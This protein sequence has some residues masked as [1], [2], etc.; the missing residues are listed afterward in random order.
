MPIDPDAMID[1]LLEYGFDTD[2]V[3]DD[4]EIRMACPL[5]ADD[6]KRLYIE[7]ESGIWLCFRCDERGDL[8]DLFHRVLGLDVQESFE[9]RRKVRHRPEPEFRFGRQ[10]PAPMP[11]I[12]LPAEF[13][14]LSVDRRNESDQGLY[15][16]YLAGRHVPP[17]RAVAYGM[18]V[19]ASGY[20]ANRLIIPVRYRDHLYTFVARALD[21]AEPKV[22]YP[23]GSRRSD[24]LFNL[25]R[26]E[27][28]V[29]LHPLV[30]TEGAFD[31]LRMPNCAVA[32]LGS[33]M[34]PMQVTLLGRMPITWRPFIILMDGDSA[35]RKA[36]YQIHRL[37]W[38]HNLPH[39]EARLPDGL[40]PSAAPAKVLRKVIQETLDL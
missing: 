17:E 16:E 13:E 26:L 14:P 1:L 25:D 6:S 19:C 29:P 33:Q 32:L 28:I 37:L 38:S 22:L 27:R 9:A 21:N 2:M 4:T 31:A 7:A 40:D 30:I 11:G 5:C 20:Y 12:N 34:S 15:F 23:E 35:G 10:V 3:E 36:S 18:G 24:M 8:F 39:V